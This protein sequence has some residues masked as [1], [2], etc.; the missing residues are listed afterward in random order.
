MWTYAR[1]GRKFSW[2]VYTCGQQVGKW[3]YL[4]GYFVTSIVG[5]IAEDRSE[6]VDVF[7]GESDAGRYCRNYEY[8]SGDWQRRGNG[9]GISLGS[10]TGKRISML[11]RA[12]VSDGD[13]TERNGDDTAL[14][15]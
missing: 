6:Y 8:N 7:S 14:Y 11:C 5:T 12:S 4:S 13:F 9:E 15:R 3:C 2:S 1:T 10:G